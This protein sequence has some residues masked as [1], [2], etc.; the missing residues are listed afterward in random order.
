MEQI[1]GG[2]I[3]LWGG[4]REERLKKTGGGRGRTV[5]KCNAKHGKVHEERCG[6]RQTGELGGKR[7]R[8]RERERETGQRGGT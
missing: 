3:E 6:G 1:R 5:K 8:E 4:I 2:K 7:E